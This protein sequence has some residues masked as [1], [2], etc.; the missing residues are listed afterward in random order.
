MYHVDI[1][2]S[3]DSAFKV[4][5]NDYEFVVDT[6]GNGITPPDA[7]L[8]SLGTCVGVYLRK[9]AEGARIELKQLSISADAEFTK[10]PPYCFKQINVLVD[11][12]GTKLEENRKEGLLRFIKNCPVH[13]T[14]KADPIVD[15]KIS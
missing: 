9:Y 8:A 1:I 14:L 7:L 10:E 3:G 6:K 15:I 2:N 12:K 5:S 13:N 4:K 11:F